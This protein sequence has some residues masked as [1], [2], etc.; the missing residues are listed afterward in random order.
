MI[1]YLT[2]FDN[3]ELDLSVAEDSYTLSKKRL[4]PSSLVRSMVLLEALY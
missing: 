4:H 1:K 3:S 2:A